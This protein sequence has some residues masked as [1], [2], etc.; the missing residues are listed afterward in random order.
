MT[1]ISADHSTRPVRFDKIKTEPTALAAGVRRDINAS[2]KPEASACGSERVPFSSDRGYALQTL[3]PL[4]GA[5][6]LMSLSLDCQ[7]LQAQQTADG[8]PLEYIESSSP[9][10]GGGVVSSVFYPGQ[11]MPSNTAAPVTG[12]GHSVLVRDTPSDSNQPRLAQ[13]PTGYVYPPANY[14]NPP[15]VYNNVPA[16]P[17]PQQNYYTTPV[18]Q[19]VPS[20]GVPVPWNRSFRPDCVGCGTNQP[21]YGSP[22]YGPAGLAGLQP[23]AATLPPALPNAG[24]YPAPQAVPPNFAPPQ[25]PVYQP[26]VQLQN[27][28]PNTYPGKGIVGS[29]KLY[30]DGQPVR[31][32][33]RY[34]IIP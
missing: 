24:A 25:R 17:Y 21:T 20:L 31:N 22:V 3:I 5:A 18:A 23:P 15:A 26:L 28:Q 6:L 27:M 4:I 16:T 14:A 34:L 13:V 19:Q 12:Q 1:E 2:A 30:V 32:L 33:M 7:L 10:P 29:P 9:L 11:Q 8:R